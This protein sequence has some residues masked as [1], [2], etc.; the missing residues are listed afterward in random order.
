MILPASFEGTK[1]VNSV[2]VVLHT[3]VPDWAFQED[4]RPLYEFLSKEILTK[5]ALG[6]SAN[7][8]GFLV[9]MF[10]V[11]ADPMMVCIN[12]I[13]TFAS[14]ETILLDEGCLSYP[15]LF[16]KIERPKSVRMKWFDPEGQMQTQTFD[17]MTA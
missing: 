13:I 12:P 2:D 5:G 15:G 9:R 6:V 10:V 8:F 11:R 3:P 17:G 1:L 7:Q 4:V 16:V 14:D